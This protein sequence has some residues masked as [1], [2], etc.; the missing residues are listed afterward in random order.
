M[1]ALKPFGIK[2][3]VTVD[4]SAYQGAKVWARSLTYHT[5]KDTVKNITYF[6]TDS[7]GKYMID[8]AN[9]ASTVVSDT[10]RVFCQAGEDKAYADVTVNPATA[11]G[12]TQDFAFDSNAQGLTDGLKD[13]PNTDGTEALLHN[14]LRKGCKDGM[15]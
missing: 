11:A 5:H 12:A 1:P 2:G 14:Q 10:V 9:I 4:G 15:S 7:S 13:T 8:V 3:T 6:Y